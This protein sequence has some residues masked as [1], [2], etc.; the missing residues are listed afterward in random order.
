MDDAVEVN[1]E[2]TPVRAPLSRRLR[3]RAFVGAGIVAV[4]IGGGLRLIPAYSA[5]AAT[6]G[7]QG[8]ASTACAAK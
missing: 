7:G 5:H 6:T 1:V 8:A 3:A 4:L 2:E